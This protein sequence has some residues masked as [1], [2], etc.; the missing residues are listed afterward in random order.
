MPLL[1][2]YEVAKRIREQPWGQRITLFALTGWA[3]IPT[4]AARARPDSTRT[5]SSRSTWRR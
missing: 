3:R 5:W 1:D 4:A 2:G